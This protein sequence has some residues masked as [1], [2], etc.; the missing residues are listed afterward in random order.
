MIDKDDIRQVLKALS[1]NGYTK[2][3][4][5]YDGGNDDGSFY[6][7]TFYKGDKTETVDWNKV[8]E[9]KSDDDEDF[10]NDNFMELVYGDH[11]RINQY[12][13]FAGDYSVH[14]TI[15]I[16]TLTGLVQD[17]GEESTWK[18]VDRECNVYKDEKSSWY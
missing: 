10:D 13:S 8:L 6:D 9:I 11:G 3:T 18:S 2:V 1:N 7:P 15:T 17:D 4:I 12:Y 14:G 5:E 16:D